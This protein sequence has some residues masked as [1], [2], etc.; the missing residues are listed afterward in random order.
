MTERKEHEIGEKDQQ[1][2]PNLGIKCA[3]SAECRQWVSSLIYFS[4]PLTSVTPGKLPRKIWGE[5]LCV[6]FL[7]HLKRNKWLKRC[8]IISEW[9]NNEEKRL[10]ISWSSMV[11]GGERQGRGK[12]ILVNAVATNTSLKHIQFP[13]CENLH[14]KEQ[15]KKS[16]SGNRVQNAKCYA[17]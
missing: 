2:Y 3:G 9:S 12:L 14:M 5:K 13:W 8:K 10:D 11:N 7:M 17:E 16:L 1:L 15:A 6:F 4:A